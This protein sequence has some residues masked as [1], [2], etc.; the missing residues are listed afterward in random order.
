[1]Y[2]GKIYIFTH[3]NPNT[4][5]VWCDDIVNGPKVPDGRWVKSDSVVWNW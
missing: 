3:W 4:N 5:E 2:K 1:M